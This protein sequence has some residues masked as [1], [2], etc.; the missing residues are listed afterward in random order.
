MWGE[1]HL[2]GFAGKVAYAQMLN[3]ASEI[4]F[5]EG[6]PHQQAQNTTMAG[7]AGT[8]VLNLPIQ[9][10][11]VLVPVIEIFLKED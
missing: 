10:P 11:N 2:D 5:Q 3:D 8:V 9:R 4:T 7:E 1:E 6:D